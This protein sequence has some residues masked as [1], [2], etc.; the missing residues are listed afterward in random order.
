MPALPV[1][2]AE[3]DPIDAGRYIGT[4]ASE[5]VELVV[6]QD[7]NGRVWLE[8]TPKGVLAQLGREVER[9][10]LVRFDDDTLVPVEPQR[11]IHALH[12]F[13]GDDGSGR[14]LYV[15]NGRATRRVQTT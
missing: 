7:G 12:V 9:Q 8:Q 11:G 6:S 10:E 3:R 2:P 14:A 15:H 1:P 5:I 4:Y 13:V